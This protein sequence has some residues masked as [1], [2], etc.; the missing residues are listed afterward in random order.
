MT[1]MASCC[2]IL[3]FVGCVHAFNICALPPSLLMHQIILIIFFVDPSKQKTA[4]LIAEKPL[5]GR[6][7]VSRLRPRS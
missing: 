7:C 1:C 5:I 3:L 6:S 2:R 4:E